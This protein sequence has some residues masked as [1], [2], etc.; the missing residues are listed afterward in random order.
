MCRDSHLW[1]AESSTTSTI[2]DAVAT[3]FQGLFG[4]SPH[5]SVAVGKSTSQ[6]SNNGRSA[7]ASVASHLVA[8]FVSR[9][10]SHSFVAVV[11]CVD[12][13]VHD[14]GMTA[15]IEMIAQSMN[16]FSTFGCVAARHGFVD[17]CCDDFAGF[18]I[19]A[20]VT[21]AACGTL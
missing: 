1:R 2:N 14:F 4:L 20:I 12:E 17:K 5:T 16:G 13:R 10:F 21:A 8:D 7:D 11:K 6:S 19:V 3:Q 15:A 9:F 18:C